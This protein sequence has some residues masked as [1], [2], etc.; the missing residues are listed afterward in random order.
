MGSE[1]PLKPKSVFDKHLAAARN[2]RTT[3]TNIVRTIAREML[4]LTGVITANT[5][6]KGGGSGTLVDSHITDDGTDVTI[7]SRST[8]VSSSSGATLSIANAGSGSAASITA[9]GAAAALQIT[10]GSGDAIDANGIVKAPQ[11]QQTTGAGAGKIPVSDAVGKFTLSTLAAAGI[12][13]G[14]GTTDA[15]A[16]WSSST[17]LTACRI[18]RNTGQGKIEIPWLSG[19]AVRTLRVGS[20]NASNDQDA[21]QGDSH[22]GDGVG[23]QSTNGNGVFGI[24]VHGNGVRAQN[25]DATEPAFLCLNTGGGPAAHIAGTALIDDDTV[26]NGNVDLNGDIDVSGDSTLHGDLDVTGDI[27]GGGTLDIV[28]GGGANPAGSFNQSNGANTAATM[29]L[30]HS[31]ALSPALR[32]LNAVKLKRVAV[33]GSMTTDGSETILGITGAAGPITISLTDPD[34]TSDG[35][36]LWIK[37][38][39]NVITGVNTLTVVS[40][41]GATFDGAVNMFFNT[42]RIKALIY[43]DGTG[44]QRII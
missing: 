18:F 42:G 40:A 16:A 14:T 43:W 44:W 7:T 38:E 2:G 10:A 11:F 24:S 20:T 26:I 37:D 13:S 35:V 30:S 9:S 12:V 21:I 1:A 6:P 17:A 5:I 34:A 25:N 33:G 29:Q 36:T 28:H 8:V 31:R 15:L 39:A 23:G 4:T 41:S 22:D 3:L 19:D 27:T 32:V